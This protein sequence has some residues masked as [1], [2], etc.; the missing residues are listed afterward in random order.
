MDDELDWR[1]S[2][3]LWR[4]STTYCIIPTKGLDREPKFSRMSELPETDPC[5][6]ESIRRVSYAHLAE[7]LHRV[8]HVL[9]IK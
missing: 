8:L 3:I 9:D 6:S 5:H 1:I 7:A 2:G 4:R